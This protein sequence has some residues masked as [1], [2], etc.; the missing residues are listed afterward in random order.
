LR[1]NEKGREIPERLPGQAGCTGQVYI[2]KSKSKGGR[3]QVRKSSLPEGVATV[4]IGEK[5]V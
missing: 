3:S 2:R 1:K 5:K 4:K